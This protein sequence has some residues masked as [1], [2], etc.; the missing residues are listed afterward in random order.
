MSMKRMH[1]QAR[2]SAYVIGK[3]HVRLKEY[4]QYFAQ[5]LDAA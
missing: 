5:P 4:N 3:F 2:A 1:T